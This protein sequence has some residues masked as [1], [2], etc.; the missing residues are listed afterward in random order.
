M[1]KWLKIYS[2]VIVVL[3]GLSFGIAKFNS[4]RAEDLF[5]KKITRLNEVNRLPIPIRIEKVAYERGLFSSNAK[6][7]VSVGPQAI[8]TLNHAISHGPIPGITVETTLDTED[9]ATQQLLRILPNNFAVKDIRITTEAGLGGIS[10]RIVV[11]AFGINNRRE[12]LNVGNTTLHIENDLEFTSAKGEIVLSRFDFKQKEKSLHVEDLAIAFD[13]NKKDG[14]FIG[15]SQA[16]LSNFKVEDQGAARLRIASLKMEAEGDLDDGK[17]CADSSIV[18]NDLSIQGKNFASVRADLS[19]QRVDAL[20]FLRLLSDASGFAANN[21]EHSSKIKQAY[22]KMFSGSPQLKLER[23]EVQAPEGPVSMT[24]S[25]GMTDAEVPQNDNRIDNNFRKYGIA[26]LKGNSSKKALQSL[27]W[28]VAALESYG[29]RKLDSRQEERVS[30][31]AEGAISQMVANNFLVEEG[32]GYQTKFSFDRGIMEKNGRKDDMVARASNQT[33]VSDLKNARTACEAFYAD[34]MRYPRDM[35]ELENSGRVRFSENVHCDY[36][37]V[38]DQKSYAL[39]AYHES[40]NKIYSCNSSSPE[41][42]ERSR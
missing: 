3:V 41:I 16:R 22:L 38:N 23:F 25:I 29:P 20:E 21:Y 36:A 39:T 42:S 13:S 2:V 30:R 14:I 27:M 1:G 24:A 34:N 17:Y 7:K 9:E 19:L 8:A 18:A 5:K 31:L 26:E 40:G 10:N 28:A 33:A 12:S 11:P 15:T 37:A 4:N 6:S 32:D 35:A